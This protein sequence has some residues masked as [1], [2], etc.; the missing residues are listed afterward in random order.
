[1][2]P[3]RRGSSFFKRMYSVRSCGWIMAFV[4]MD[5]KT[6]VLII[7]LFSVASLGQDVNKEG[8]VCTILVMRN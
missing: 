3:F 7:L 5:I 2:L 8:I 4:V 1:M 6:E